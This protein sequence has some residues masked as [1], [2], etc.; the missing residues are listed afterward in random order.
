MQVPELEPQVIGD[1]P[2]T[3]IL[4]SNNP[5]AIAVTSSNSSV[6]SVETISTSSVKLRTHAIGAVTLTISQPASVGFTAVTL[7]R[8]VAVVRR[9]QAP[10]TLTSLS[11]GVGV[12]LSLTTAGGSGTGETSFALVAGGS[13]DCS[14][15]GSSL[16]RVTAGTCT[17]IVTKA[18]DD[19]HEAVTSEPT[20]VTFLQALTRTLL[21]ETITP[22]RD[23]GGQIA[24]S[25]DFGT[26]LSD[27]A[28]ILDAQGWEVTRVHYRMEVRV[29]E[30][31]RYV[32]VSF[33][34]WTG[35]TAD[36]L[37]I[38]DLEPATQNRPRLTIRE[39]VENMAVESNMTLDQMTDSEKAISSGVVTGSG[40]RG[41]LELWPF[42][43]GQGAS[44]NGPA[45]SNNGLFDFNDTPST[46]NN[47]GSFQVHDVTTVGA[48]RTVLAWNRHFDTVPDVGLGQRLVDHPDWTFAQGNG[49]GTNNWKLQIFADLRLRVPQAS[50]VVTSLSGAVGQP[51]T[52]TTSGGSGSGLVTYALAM[53]ASPDCTI[54]GAELT[55]STAGTCTVTATKE[56]DT[57]Y[58]DASSEPTVVT[59]VDLMH[60][61][62]NEGGTL[63]FTAPQGLQFVE[64]MFASYGTPTG[65]G[66]YA[67]GSCHAANS[68]NI[69]SN[70]AVGA[71]SFTVGALNSVFG[72]PCGGTVKRLAVSVRL[73][74]QW[75]PLVATGGTESE[76]TIDGVEYR[77]HT[78]TTVGAE[79]FT[80]TSPGTTGE[81]HYL[82]VAG[83]GGG[84]GASLA[85]VNTIGGAGGGGAGGFLE[86]SAIVVSS[87]YSLSVGAGG[88]GS[89]SG[90]GANG[91]NSFFDAFAIAVGGG[92][93]GGAD[94]DTNG[95]S[96]GSGGGAGS[97][98]GANSG[99]ARTSGQGSLGG[100]GSPTNNKGGGGGGGAGGVGVAGRDDD[101]GGAG[102]SGRAT[103]L[104]TT[105]LAEDLAIGHV[106]QGQVF[107]SGGGGGGANNSAGRQGV[108][109][110][111]GGGQ[112][113]TAANPSVAPANGLPNT[114]GGGGG[115]TDCMDLHTGGNGGS[116][117][118]IIR[119]RLSAP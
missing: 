94:L 52:L 60:G 8:Q 102:G 93:G 21:Y 11:G 87:A 81:V 111:G 103:S 69:V 20:A 14:L 77:L 7:T 6:V 17:V 27:R 85:C 55:R 19:Q 88:Q 9:T 35:V 78:F 58:L 37:R 83:G 36:G 108:G 113:G 2:T 16:T 105:S 75:N 71:T 117:I 10:L 28:R 68:L 51:R 80:V 46:N 34:P 110:V 97:G 13:P 5:A 30:N 90:A 24:Y 40:R 62:V 104:M 33:D 84:G 12:A 114:G 99:G 47:Y 92:G 53:D 22:T 38:P 43:Y 74:P 86:G 25:Q 67:T 112:G 59:F 31:L 61:V 106:H 76:I 89:S 39:F 109:G 73:G 18:A 72:D 3:L 23:S 79:T 118:V 116:G 65:S 98:A 44:A 54:E 56:G 66:P 49:F 96:G 57:H 119:Y 107:F 4:V 26:D 100:D 1:G 82:V 32:E 15:T 101:F 115:G 29:G 63:T 42:N 45:G 91:Q 41:Y 95:V 48:E 50:L 70:I 64:V